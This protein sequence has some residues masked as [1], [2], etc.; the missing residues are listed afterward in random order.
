MKIVY[1]FMLE[2]FIDLA[3]AFQ[4]TNF[5]RDIKEDYNF[6]P[7]EFTLIS[8]KYYEPKSDIPL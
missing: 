2:G 3:R 1:E 5:L 4:L 7:R 8:T 6:V